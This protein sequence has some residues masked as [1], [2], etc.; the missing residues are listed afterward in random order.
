[1]VQIPEFLLIVY[2]CIKRWCAAQNAQNICEDKRA[3]H[4]HRRNDTAAHEYHVG[5]VQRIP[6]SM[7]GGNTT[8]KKVLYIMKHQKG[9]IL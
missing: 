5:D 7:V 2:A 6:D 4:H 8:S 3:V 1:M 9:S